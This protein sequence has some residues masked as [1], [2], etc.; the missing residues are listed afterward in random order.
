MTINDFEQINILLTDNKILFSIPSMMLMLLKS[1]FPL[2]LTKYLLYQS[3]LLL[4][5]KVA[6]K[7]D[8]KLVC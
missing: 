3:C 6:N 5:I 8:A 7:G 2:D 4:T 1:R